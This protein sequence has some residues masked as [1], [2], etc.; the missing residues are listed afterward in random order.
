VREASVGVEIP[1]CGRYGLGKVAR[2]DECFA[3]VV[4]GHKWYLSNGSTYAKIAG[5]TVYLSR[6]ILA[7]AD[8]PIPSRIEHLN[9]DRL[10]CRLENLKPARPSLE[11]PGPILNPHPLGDDA[12]R[13]YLSAAELDQSERVLRAYLCKRRPELALRANEALWPATGRIVTLTME[14]LTRTRAAWW[15]GLG[16]WDAHTFTHPLLAPHVGPTPPRHPRPGDLWHDT[17]GLPH[18]VRDYRPAGDWG[19]VLD[20]VRPG[21]PRRALRSVL[22]TLLSDVEVRVRWP[23]LTAL[24]ADVQ[25]MLANRMGPAGQN[26]R[27]AYLACATL[28]AL[29]DV[30]MRRVVEVLADYRRTRSSL[31]AEAPTAHG[32]MRNPRP[33]SR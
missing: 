24:N 6:Y 12:R 19:I 31:S 18:V 16:E 33:A 23:R 10:D 30:E 22:S 1:L 27:P 13:H 7:L 26:G 25:L 15:S 20:H 5:E 8:V 11:P 29:L 28:A 21:M 14:A 2:V 17:S 32:L 3:D 9:R 4:R